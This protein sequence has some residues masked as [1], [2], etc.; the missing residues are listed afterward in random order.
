MARTSPPRLTTSSLLFNPSYHVRAVRGKSHRPIVPASRISDTVGP[1][2]VTAHPAH[3]R[4]LRCLQYVLH[5]TRLRPSV[6]FTALVRLHRLKTGILAARCFSD[7]R[8]SLSA[9]SCATTH[10]PTSPG[11]LSGPPREQP[12]GARDVCV[13]G[14][15]GRRSRDV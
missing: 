6:T 4:A 14:V 8:L 15:A 11:L 9:K 3:S 5:R 12:D 10:T 2:T 1:L 13:H 7:Y